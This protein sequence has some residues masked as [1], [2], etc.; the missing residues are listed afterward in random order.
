MIRIITTFCLLSLLF[1]SCKPFGKKE[2]PAVLL[3]ELKDKTWY[4]VNYQPQNPGQTSNI[5]DKIANESANAARTGKGLLYNFFQDGQCS[6]AEGNQYFSGTWVYEETTKSVNCKITSG[7]RSKNIELNITAINPENMT[8]DITE[9]GVK[10]AIQTR[11]DKYVY[12]APDHNPWHPENNK[13][14][15]KPENAESDKALLLRFKN[16]IQHYITLLQAMVDNNG[17]TLSV[18]NSPS[19]IQIY[20]GGI[21]IRDTERIDKEWFDTFFNQADADKC[22][23]IFENILRESPSYG[24]SSGSW[25]KD[26]LMVLKSIY[27][28]ILEKE[29]SI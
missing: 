20:N 3:S 12:Q 29:K 17:K 24:K 11:T 6:F 22:L 21:G 9:N 28:Q 2:D 18:V 16:H 5:A 19:C 14:R 8:A 15:I 10:G 7:N 25:V 4:V 23:G 13:W 27:A 1:I 26:D